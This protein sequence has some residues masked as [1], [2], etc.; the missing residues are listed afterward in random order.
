[1]T[2]SKAM[3]CNLIVLT[4]TTLLIRFVALSFNVY[5][6]GKLG[7]Y[8]M[9]VYT[10]I[11]SV[12]AFAVTLATSGVNLAAT[13]LTAAAMGKGSQLA[14]R[15]AMRRCVIYS[16]AFGCFA[17]VL[18]VLLAAPVS[19]KILHEPD[20]V[21]PL[22]IMSVSLPCISLSSALY[23]YFTAQRRV[24]KTSA[25]QIFEQ[26]VKIGATVLLIGAL[27]PKGAKYACVAV[28][29][30]G[31]ISEI[32]SFTVSFIL[33]RR[34]LAKYVG[35]TGKPDPCVTRSL[36]SCALPVAF[37]AYVRSGLV[38]VEH[39]L[40]PRGLRSYGSS[41]EAALASYGVLHGMV[42]PVILFPMTV[43][44]AFAGLLVPEISECQARGDAGRIDR[45]AARV[46]Q[47]SL[48]FSCGV[49]GIMLCFSDL[50]GNAIYHNAEAGGMI[51]L[52][53]PLVPVM[54]LD[55]VT[56]GMLKGL[57]EQV[58]CMKVNI[59]DAT[60]SVI[61]VRFLVP[62]WG[63]YGYVGIV[64]A[65]ELINASLSVARLLSLTNLKIKPIDWLVKPLFCVFGATSLAGIAVYGIIGAGE[66]L[67]AVLAVSL[68]AVG[69]FALMR[70]C[71]G[72]S[73][74]DLRWFRRAVK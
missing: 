43:M 52:L 72:I 13:R 1:M 4:A 59:A 23:G 51:R 62:L 30:G 10:L 73:A 36:L 3:F 58:Y 69:Y 57:G 42:F 48:G 21:L 16:L 46:F 31:A 34:D 28:I 8:G 38:T 27:A 40:I 15:Q 70:L 37:T 64:I 54:Y 53:A 20:C 41:P 32:C 68:S 47:A 60:M 45:I 65:M 6:S 7:A 11:T 74:E 25:A 67:S 56:D 44:S 22:K 29:A 33:Y 49:A 14:V 71:G 2:R 35:R 9:G 18:L 39:L 26:L 66:T 63:V 5:V 12:G 61:L 17:A 50:L 19:L 24:I 55:H